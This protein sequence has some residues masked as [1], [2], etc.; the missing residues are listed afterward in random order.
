MVSTL[1]SGSSSLGSSPGSGHCVVLGTMCRFMPQKPEISAG[2]I[3]HL[4]R[5]QT[6]PLPKVLVVVRKKEENYCNSSPR[7]CS[8]GAQLPQ[9]T[10]I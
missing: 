2:L 8:S 5:M 3:D 1:L 7:L 4:A 6:L 9:A 10:N